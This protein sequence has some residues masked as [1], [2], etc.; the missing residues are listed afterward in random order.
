MSEKRATADSKHAGLPQT[1][2]A[3]SK[4]A[5]LAFER[6]SPQCISLNA[7]VCKKN[8]AY[9]LLG[10][11]G[12]FRDVLDQTRTTGATKPQKK[13]MAGCCMNSG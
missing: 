12:C 11:T 3:A 7:A 2:Q 1:G 5:G 13:G 4:R 9:L 8:T 6:L 10:A